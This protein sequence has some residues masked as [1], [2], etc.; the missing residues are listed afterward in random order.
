MG[1]PHKHHSYI[2]AFAQ[3]QDAVRVRKF[4]HSATKMQLRERVDGVIYDVGDDVS[5]QWWDDQPLRYNVTQVV[6]MN[7]AGN[8]HSPECMMREIKFLDVMSYPLLRDI[9]VVLAL[10][11]WDE[12]DRRISFKCEVFDPRDDTGAIYRRSVGVKDAPLQ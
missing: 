1:F 2:V 12:S 7:K 10:A 5:Q 11:G 9:G 3:R 4:A 6:S 8:I